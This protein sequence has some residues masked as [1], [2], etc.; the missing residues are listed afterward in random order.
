MR[1]MTA[2][3]V[4]VTC[5]CVTQ[6]V[7]CIFFASGAG[8]GCDASTLCEEDAPEVCGEDGATYTCAAHATCEAV[9][10]DD[11]GASCGDVMCEDKGDCGVFCAMGF[12][13]DENGC[14]TCDCYVPPVCPAKPPCA[15]G[16][17]PTV[18]DFDAKGCPRYVCPVR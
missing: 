14:E 13:K 6:G 12:Q 2:F 11:S 10:I 15:G 3:L 9:G 5:L 16:K 4:F 18:S 17:D 1:R 7:G 8:D